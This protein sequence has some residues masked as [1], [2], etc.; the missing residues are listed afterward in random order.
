MGSLMDIIQLII[1]VITCIG[2]IIAIFEFR[3]SKKI[4]II[5]NDRQIKQNTLDA[6]KVREDEFHEYNSVIYKIYGKKIISN[7]ELQANKDMV[8]LIKDYFNKLEF[9]CTGVNIGIYDIDVFERLYGDVM[10]RIYH[11]FYDYIRYRRED[12]KTEIVYAEFESVVKKMEKIQQRKELVNKNA[13][14]K[15][16]L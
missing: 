13:E 3:Q 15:M 8:V 16:K 5:L 10:V 4:E 6:F 1:D 9:L 7:D 14:Y 2:V 11:Q 12:R